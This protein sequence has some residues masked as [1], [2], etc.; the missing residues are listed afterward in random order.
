M[1]PSKKK[2]KQADSVPDHCEPSEVQLHSAVEEQLRSVL[3]PGWRLEQVTDPDTGL[4]SWRID[5]PDCFEI[6][7]GAGEAYYGVQVL[8]PC[9][10]LFF[11]GLEFHMYWD[12]AARPALMIDTRLDNLTRVLKNCFSDPEH[13]PPNRTYVT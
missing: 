7:K 2:R 5:M 11:Y 6:T 8:T 9:K 13:F 12:C 1:W 4:F 10:I 3:H